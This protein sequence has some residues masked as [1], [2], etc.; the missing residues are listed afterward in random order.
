MT[1]ERTVAGHR[2]LRLLARG[3]RSQVWLAAG[4]LVL[5]ALDA[6]VPAGQP[7]REAEALHRA[8]GEHVVELLDVSLGDDGRRARVPAAPA[9][10]AGR[11]AGR[12]GRLWMRGRP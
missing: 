5:K 8:R 2:V 1:I 6:P 11:A 3:D 10:F 9:R 7:G 4:D 12:G